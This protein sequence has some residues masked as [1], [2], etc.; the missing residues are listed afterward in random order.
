MIVF[1]SFK[2]HEEIFWDQIF[3]TPSS[4]WENLHYFQNPA[5]NLSL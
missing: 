2:L 4:F 1:I 3:I 5:T